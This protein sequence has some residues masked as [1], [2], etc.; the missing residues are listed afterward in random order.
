MSCDSSWS[1]FQTVSSPTGSG[2]V[3]SKLLESGVRRED[4]ALLDHGRG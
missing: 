1:M 4:Q 2:N 3:K